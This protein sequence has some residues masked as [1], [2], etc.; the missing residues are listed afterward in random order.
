MDPLKESIARVQ[1]QNIL[2][3]AVEA[4]EKLS[5][6]TDFVEKAKGNALIRRIMKEGL[7]NDAVSALG[8]T[9]DLLVDAASKMAVAK[10]IIWQMPVKTPLVRFYKASRGAVWRV[11]NGPP[12]QSPSRGDT[13]DIS[14]TY[15]W[16]KDATFSQSYLEDAPFPV[17]QREVQC[18]G[19]L[20]EEQLTKDIIAL[21]D[22]IAA[23]NLAGGAVV[24]TATSGTLVWADVV[25]AW[26]Q[27]KVAGWGKRP[28]R[29]VL[30]CHPYEIGDLW[31]DD[32]FISALYAGN[33]A[34]FARGVLGDAYL[35]FKVVESDLM[36]LDAGG[37]NGNYA[38]L[39]NVDV[40]AANLMRR[41]KL[42]QPYT[43]K[44]EEGILATSRY[45]LGTLREDAVCRIDIVH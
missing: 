21:Y 17:I 12:T 26:T 38:Y 37:G 9:Y 8:V 3:E 43:D 24:A 11:S 29:K 23:A 30:L 45:G 4:D 7:L 2:K 32:K 25:K 6:A 20:L 41:D 13:K 10:D 44:L 15:E 35:G 28:G 18:A 27:F 14:V 42:T 5:W 34:D 39:M 22:G 16:G 36:A 33:A 40:A 1:L 31:S 19:E